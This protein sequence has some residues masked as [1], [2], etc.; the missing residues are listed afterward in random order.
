MVGSRDAGTA[1]EFR[2]TFGPL[3]NRNATDRRRPQRY[4]SA[5]EAPLGRPIDYAQLE[6]PSPGHEPNYSRAISLALGLSPFRLA[7]CGS[8]QHFPCGAPEPDH[9]MSMRR[10]TRLTNGSSKK[11]ET[12]ATGCPALMYYSLRA[13]PSDPARYPCDGRGSLDHVWIGRNR[14]SD[15]N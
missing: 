8:H 14:G 9:A 11:L 2:Q 10:F 15:R 1:N 13:N 4:L 12:L 3:T 7:R 6:S 5:V